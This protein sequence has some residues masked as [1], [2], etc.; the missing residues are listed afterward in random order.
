MKCSIDLSLLKNNDH[1]V[2]NIQTNVAAGFVLNTEATSKQAQAMPRLAV[3]G[4]EFSFD[5]FGHVA[6]I[7]SSETL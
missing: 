6:V 1:V 2:V 5:E 7:C 4:V 3:L